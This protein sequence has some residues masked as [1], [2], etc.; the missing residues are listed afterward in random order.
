MEYVLLPRIPHKVYTY[1]HLK[2]LVRQYKQCVY[3]MYRFDL[4]RHT[5]VE[6]SREGRDTGKG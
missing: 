6:C 1:V 5:V 3:N 2:N 4:V